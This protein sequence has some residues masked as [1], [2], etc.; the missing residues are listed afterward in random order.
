MKRKT[1]CVFS[2][3]L[4]L[5]IFCTIL[6]QKI[7]VEMLTQVEVKTVNGSKIYMGDIN[8]P[9]GVLFK[10]EYSPHLYEVA[11]GTGWESGTRIREIDNKTYTVDTINQKV[12]LSPGK[13]YRFV[14][15][16]SR[17]PNYGELVE[18]IEEPET[19]PDTYLVCYPDGVPE[20]ET[21][22]EHTALLVHS[23]NA[24]LLA[25][26]KST[27]PFFEHRAKNTLS[28]LELPGM[29]VFSLTEIE[30]FLSQF[31]L[32]TMLAMLLIM[33]VMLWAASCIFSNWENGRAAVW[34]NAGL[35]LLALCFLPKLLEQIDLPTSL[36]PSGNILSISFYQSNFSLIFESLLKLDLISTLEVKESMF[37][38]VSIIWQSCLIGTIILIMTEA[39]LI[40][41]IKRNREKKVEIS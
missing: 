34:L 17:H 3:I 10:D 11:E 6:S 31:P 37:R 32:L 27:F 39:I 30:N 38:Q 36:L 13:D 33:P 24:L 18:I 22:P 23:E 15:T 16:A 25:V 9:I 1:L 41:L 40:R 14:L 19:A 5:L 2:L 26:E 29:R 21:L 8:L 7:E 12:T 28:T 4:F 35:I 20:Y